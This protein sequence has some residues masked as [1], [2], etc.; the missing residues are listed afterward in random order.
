MFHPFYFEIVVLIYCVLGSIQT[1]DTVLGSLK[2]HTRP[3]RAPG[4]QMEQKSGV[5]KLF[6]I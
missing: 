3:D 5:P 2:S 1:P 4:C 6:C